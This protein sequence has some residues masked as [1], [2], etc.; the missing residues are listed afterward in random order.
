MNNIADTSGI[1]V[2]FTTK[3]A[4]VICICAQLCDRPVIDQTN[5]YGKNAMVGS[6]IDTVCRIRTCSVHKV[7]AAVALMSYNNVMVFLFE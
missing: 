3:P 5:Y 1:C 7:P 2:L 4:N 6:E